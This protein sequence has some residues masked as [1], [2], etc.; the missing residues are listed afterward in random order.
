[1]PGGDSRLSA[2]VGLDSSDFKNG[3]TAIN[4]ELKLAE[5]SFRATASTLDDWSNTSEGLEA[6]I[7]SLTKQVSLQQEK[8]EGLRLQAEHL[9][10]VH[11]ENSVEAQN[12]TIE[13]NKETKKLNELQKELGHTET[14]LKSMKGTT[15]GVKGA[16][17]DL[18]T[19]FDA[20]KQQVPILGTAFNLLSNPIALAAAAAGAFAAI[21]KKS[22]GEF[23]AYNQQIREMALA[24]G[25]GAEEI[26]RIIQVGD[27]WMINASDIR[28]SLEFMNKKGITPSIENLAKMADEYVNAADK[29]KWAEEA[30]EI[31][32]RGYTTLIPLLALGGDELRK[33]TDAVEKNLIA[34]EKTIA[35]SLEY[36]Q[37]MDKL[38]D[39]A[40][41]LQYELAA[42]AVPAI[43][44]V[45]DALAEGLRVGNE[46]TQ[47]QKD[48]D[49]AFK[50]GIIT[51]KELRD[52][53]NGGTLFT[54]DLAAAE[55][56]LYSRTHMLKEADDLV[57][58][59]SDEL[60]ASISDN[61]SYALANERAL[62]KLITTKKRE[63]EATEA[64]N[65]ELLNATTAFSDLNTAITSQ[66]G[67]AMEN[68]IDGQEDLEQKMAD[69][70]TE[71]DKAISDGY[72]PLG[73]KVLEL[74]GKY[75]ELKG[76]YTANADEHDK[77]TKRIMYDMILQEASIDGLTTAEIAALTKLAE[78]WGLP[79]EATITYLEN[80]E[81]ALNWLKN[82]HG[83][84]ATFQRILEGQ[85]IAWGLTRDQAAGAKGEAQYYKD[86]IDALQNKT[87]TITTNY[88]YH[89]GPGRDY[90]AAG[91]ANF[92]VPPN[93]DNDQF[94]LN[95]SSGE[96]VIVIPPSERFRDSITNLQQLVTQSTLGLNRSQG[97]PAVGGP[98]QTVNHNS[99][100]YTIQAANPLQTSGDL[101]RQ[102]RL[103]E[104]M[105]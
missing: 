49:A 20:L 94:H 45:T 44:D 78:N 76:Q 87:I 35:M 37:T 21:T 29:S 47:V 34:T 38:K 33:Q 67:P 101:A 72:S 40:T 17:K 61:T 39:T 6:R 83:D 58:D 50:A 5:S 102:V 84:V 13:F 91:G 93:F 75:D 86:I 62:N 15:G 51:E 36:Q 97:M 23:V 59:S 2:R 18:G 7:K 14:S 89:H 104:L 56:L 66:L 95:V 8:V 12:A 46:I 26:S 90:G 24:T 11:G 69:V 98:G 103:L 41:G 48:L 81:K 16:F 53:R 99:W 22:I 64:Q 63:T 9:A 30:V 43:N 10:K 31:L 60:T 55:Q 79:Y 25:L 82:H 27:D 57:V 65:K 96:H 4:R 32:G 74:K 28:T 92:I 73:E 1:M 3:I 42:Q 77:A 88:E 80:E 54:L 71:I 100:S 19:Q 70:Q 85:G 68:F 105:H 52:V